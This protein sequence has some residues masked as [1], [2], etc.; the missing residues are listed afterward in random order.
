MIS[1]MKN[2]GWL[3]RN[4]LKSTLGSRINALLARLAKH[5]RPLFCTF[6]APAGVVLL[7]PDR[8]RWVWE[9]N[10]LRALPRYAS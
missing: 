3:G 1:H 7:L 8:P 2:D 10:S 4:Y 5:A 9:R 6:V